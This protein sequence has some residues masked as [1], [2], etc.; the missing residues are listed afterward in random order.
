MTSNEGRDIVMISIT[1]EPGWPTPVVLKNKKP[2]RKVRICRSDTLRVAKIQRTNY[3]QIST[4][5]ALYIT[6]II[7][8]NPSEFEAMKNG[9]NIFRIN[10]MQ[11]AKTCSSTD[12]NCNMFVHKKL[13]R[14]VSR[15]MFHLFFENCKIPR[16]VFLEKLQEIRLEYIKDRES[17][18][19]IDLFI[20]FK[21]IKNVSSL[22]PTKIGSQTVMSNCTAGIIPRSLQP[23]LAASSSNLF[24]IVMNKVE[25]LI[26]ESLNAPL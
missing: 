16:E 12:S 14:I 11:Y 13:G 19:D 15:S 21:G 8:G 24:G 23:H 10:D 5:F 3:I 17:I 26:E 18:L 4:Y 2:V 22:D 1:F 20:D 6:D 7:N 25:K 9:H